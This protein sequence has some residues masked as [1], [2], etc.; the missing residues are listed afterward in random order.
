MLALKTG[1][2]ANIKEGKIAMKKKE[3]LQGIFYHAA[4]V[5]ELLLAG[6]ILLM[7]LI[8]VGIM[9]QNYFGDAH[10]LYEDEAFQLFLRK[11][12]SYAI[13]I[14]FVKMLVQHCPE[15]VIDVLVFAIARQVIVEHSSIKE[16]LLR[17]LGIGMLF[18]IE[19]YLIYHN[20]GTNESHSFSRKH[21]ED[22]GEA[23]S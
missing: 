3:G 17:I 19:K 11:I 9:L 12:L 6:C 5:M 16:T 4:I 1:E 7:I 21:T 14:E 15:N 10:A 2:T 23:D 18:A 8:L 13:G 22:V 20:P